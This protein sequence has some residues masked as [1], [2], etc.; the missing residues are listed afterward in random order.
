MSQVQY[1]GNFVG[2]S[3]EDDMWALTGSVGAELMENEREQ[4]IAE[5][6]AYLERHNMSDN[7]VKVY[8]YAVRRYYQKYQEL[9]EQKV[10]LYKL[11]MMEHYKP[12]TVNLRIRAMNSYLEFMKSEYNKVL[13]VKMQQKNFLEHV[14][15][16]ADYEYLKGRLMRDGEW[17]WYYL[18]RFMGATGARVSEVIQMEVA[19]VNRGYKDIYSKDN[20]IRRIYIPK[21]LREDTQLWLRHEDKEDGPLFLNNQGNVITTSG[22]RKQLKTYAAR[23]GL[24]GEVVYPHSFRHRFA[25]NFIEK[26]GDIALLSDLLGHESIETT[27]IYLR[28]TSSEQ[29]QLVNQIVDW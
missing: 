9:D 6:A 7:T 11:Y 25:K 17:T 14:I 3:M 27:R 26:C 15:S 22:I 28:R 19:D 23:Y 20:K 2:E 10:Q 8:A 29:R 5:F 1:R 4:T 16:E 21:C 12:K 24:D 13:M 18:V